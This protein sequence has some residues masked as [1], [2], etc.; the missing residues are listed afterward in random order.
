VQGRG[1]SEMACRL[2]SN[3]RMRYYFDTEFIDR[4]YPDNVHLISIGIVSEDGREYYVEPE[5]TDLSLA[6]EW[7]KQHVIPSLEGPRKPRAQIAQEIESFVE[8]C[9]L[10]EREFWGYFP[11]YDWVL[12]C[13]LYGPMLSVPRSFPHMPLDLKQWAYHLGVPKSLFP[14]QEIG[15]HHALHDAR[16]NRDLFNFLLDL[17]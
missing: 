11:S 17:V 3:V 6:D 5:E 2:H 13:G 16:W 15:H 4:G 14:K 9:T 12:L 10:D 1:Q 7:V 8:A